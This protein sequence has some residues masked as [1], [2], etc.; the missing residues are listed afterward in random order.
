[1]RGLRFWKRESTTVTD[2]PDPAV[3]TKFGIQPRRDLSLSNLPN[4]PDTS[5]RAVSLQ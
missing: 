4:D 2:T 5:A 1:M 3:T